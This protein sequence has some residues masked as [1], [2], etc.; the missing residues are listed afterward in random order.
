MENPFDLINSRLDKIEK[1]LLRI[2]TPEVRFTINEACDYLR[3]SYA[4]LWRLRNEGEIKPIYVD[5]KPCFTQKELDNIVRKSITKEIKLPFKRNS[6]DLTDVLNTYLEDLG[7]SVRSFNCLKAERI[8]SLGELV[9]YECKELLKLRNFGQK[10]LAEIEDVL[11]EKGLSLGMDA[12]KLGIKSFFKNNQK[13]NV[14]VTP[15]EIKVWPLDKV[16]EVVELLSY[17]ISKLK[18][19]G[20]CLKALSF[21]HISNIIDLIYKKEA[22]LLK[23][24]YFNQSILN[25]IEVGLNNI[26]LCLEMPFKNQHLELFKAIWNK[27]HVQVNN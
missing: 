1:I 5:N 20:P 21:A 15:K 4:A 14:I 3:I 17:P 23:F 9:Q 25:E 27:C 2:S 26:G 10:S 19:S 7:L 22:D 6:N 16:D 24:D 18:I 13:D 11:T 12:G 8:N